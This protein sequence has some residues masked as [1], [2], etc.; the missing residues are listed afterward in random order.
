MPRISSAQ[1][2]DQIQLAVPIYIPHEDDVRWTVHVDEAEMGQNLSPPAD[3]PVSQPE[4][5]IGDA[6]LTG[7]EGSPKGTYNIAL[8]T[9]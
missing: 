7:F 6:R 3:L 2:E 1:V 4:L 8:S 5:V 9:A